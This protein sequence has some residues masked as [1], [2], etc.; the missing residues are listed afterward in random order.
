MSTFFE[1]GKDTATNGKAWAGSFIS[2]TQDTVGL[3]PPLPLRLLSY[4]KPLPFFILPYGNDS[5][6]IPSCS[7]LCSQNYH[8]IFP[9]LKALLAVLKYLG[10]VVQSIISLT[11]SLEVNSLS[12]LPLYNH[13][14]R[15]FLLEKCNAKASHIFSTKNI[16]VF[17][18]LT[19]EILGN[20]N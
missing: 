11:S 10:P 19:Y 20:I 15:N 1:L 14:H 6:D 4:G 12:V 8:G 3:E 16:G 17:H 5:D 9:I 2:C 13:T 18:I 7:K